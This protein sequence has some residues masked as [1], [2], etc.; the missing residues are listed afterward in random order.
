MVKENIGRER[1]TQVGGIGN[2]V[3]LSRGRAGGKREYWRRKTYTR[4]RN[5]QDSRSFKEEGEK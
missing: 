3:G 4:R 5:W 1:P 2:I